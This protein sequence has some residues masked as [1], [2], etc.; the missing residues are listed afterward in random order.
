MANAT[1]IYACTPDGLVILTRPG[2]LPEWLPPR[3]VLVGR[4]LAS[5]WGEPGPPIRVLAVANGELLLS[6]NGGR[7]W[8][9]VEVGSAVISASQVAMLA[10]PG[11]E[12]KP[13]ALVVGTASGLAV[14]P[15]GGA[16][17]Q[18][19]EMPQ[20]GGVV[21][22]ARDPERRD[23]IYAATDTGY[24]FE[25]GNRGQAWQQVNAT[26]LPPVSYLYVV[27]I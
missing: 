9:T 12:G 24:V 11:A 27:R 18:V 15:D 20:Q 23:R 25:S 21:A 26:P 16:S 10:V 22:L 7:S 17:W 6:E 8:E 1:I 14:S 3:R 2:T 5:V 13:P 4:H 19:I